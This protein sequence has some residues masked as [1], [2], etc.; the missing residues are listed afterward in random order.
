[1]QEFT[2]PKSWRLVFILYCPFKLS[3]PP[4]A[5]PPCTCPVSSPPHLPPTP[6][7]ATP[8]NVYLRFA[9]RFEVRALAALAPEKTHS[10]EQSSRVGR[11]ES[12]KIK[13]GNVL[14]V[15]RVV[16]DDTACHSNFRP[17]T[18]PTPRPKYTLFSGSYWRESKMF[19]KVGLGMGIFFFCFFRFLLSFIF[20]HATCTG[21]LIG[22]SL[23]HSLKS[24]SRQ[25]RSFYRYT[26][27]C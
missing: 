23:Q 5:C 18:P 8:I 1:M 4:S 11:P 24:E 17:P 21:T 6:P 7:F 13:L 16:S 25:L 20:M 22:V 10:L 9:C 3:A 26:T 14:K 15:R 27:L 2:L 12:R 19:Q